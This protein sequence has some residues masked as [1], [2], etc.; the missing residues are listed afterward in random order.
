MRLRSLDD[1]FVA[2]LRDLYSA[3]N[4]ILEALPQLAD[5]ASVGALQNAFREH[6]RRTRGQVQRLD[7]IFALLRLPL[8]DRKC[9]AIDGIL[10]EADDLLIEESTPAARDAALIAAAQRVAH[11]EIAVYGC[12][13]TYARTLG[14]EEAAR[15]LD[16]TLAEETAI[17]RKLTRI[18]EGIVNREAAAA[19]H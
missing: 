10:G 17:D 15:L 14:H 12:A 6:Q 11:Y 7:R 3:E 18:A 16:E 9:R 8:K 2:Q 1:V 4:Q 5:A 19:A 13:R